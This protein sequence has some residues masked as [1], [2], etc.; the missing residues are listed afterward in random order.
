VQVKTEHDECSVFR[1]REESMVALTFL[2]GSRSYVRIYK[3]LLVHVALEPLI[4]RTL[5]V[6][7]QSLARGKRKCP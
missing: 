5:H 7:L 1:I 3:L 6:L 4:S 2:L